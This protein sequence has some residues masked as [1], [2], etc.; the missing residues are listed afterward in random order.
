MLFTVTSTSG[1]YSPPCG[2]LGP[3]ISTATAESEWGLDFVYFMSRLPLKL[4][5][6]FVLFYTFLLYKYRRKTLTEN[7]TTPKV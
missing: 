1:L 6:F 5:L 4:A 2:F 3:E 7:D